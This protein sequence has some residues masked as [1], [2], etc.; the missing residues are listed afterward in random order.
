MDQK[1]FIRAITRF[2]AGLLL[3]AGLLFIPAGTWNYPQ[4]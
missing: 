1:L 3:V 4:G 2:S